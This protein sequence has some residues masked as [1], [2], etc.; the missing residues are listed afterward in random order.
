LKIE[1]IAN[2]LGFDEEFLTRG[3]YDWS[4]PHL[5]QMLPFGSAPLGFH[6]EAWNPG[7]REGKWAV[8]REI[9]RST[10]ALRGWLPTQP[11]RQ[12]IPPRAGPARDNP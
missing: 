8:D 1:T 10:P 4:A 6:D 2:R 7:S 11:R 9:V 12:T 3:K 5:Q